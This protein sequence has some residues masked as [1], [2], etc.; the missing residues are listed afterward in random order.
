LLIE[1]QNA[2]LGLPIVVES[3]SYLPTDATAFAARGVP[4]LSA[5]TGAHAE[6]HTPRDTPE[7]LNYEGAAKVARFMA[8]IARLLLES[9]RAPAC[10]QAAASAA[11]TPRAGLRAYL[12]T[13]PDYA[14]AL[15]P[16]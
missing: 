10:A 7:T 15:W 14:P 12:G 2:V 9:A 4:V 3:F 13:I 11:G 1:R 16:G 8:G 6:Y 5:L